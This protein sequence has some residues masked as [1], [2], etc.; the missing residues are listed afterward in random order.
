MDQ[1]LY[2]RIQELQAASFFRTANGSPMGRIVNAPFLGAP[3]AS[4]FERLVRFAD[5]TVEVGRLGVHEVHEVCCGL[6]VVADGLD[7]LRMIPVWTRDGAITVR[8]MS[9]GRC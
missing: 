1:E 2:D 6:D 7:A 3:I 8:R 5:S 4:A 9:G